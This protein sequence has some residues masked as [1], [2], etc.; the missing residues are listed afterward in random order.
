MTAS[1]VRGHP[2]TLAQRP[3]AIDELARIGQAR[4]ARLDRAAPIAN[5]LAGVGVG[6]AHAGIIDGRTSPA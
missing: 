2:H 5:V 6:L 4:G 3:V 1:Q